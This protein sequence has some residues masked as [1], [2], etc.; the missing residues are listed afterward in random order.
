MKK[1]RLIVDAKCN[2]RCA[3]CC[4][5]QFDITKLPVCTDYTP[6]DEIILTG[7]EPMLFPDRIVEIVLAIDAQ[8][9][10]HGRTPIYMN[11]AK[12]DNVDDMNNVLPWLDGV[13]LTLHNQKDVVTFCKI[14]SSDFRSVGIKS[15]HSLRVNHRAGLNLKAIPALLRRRWTFKEI[16]AVFTDDCPLPKDEVLMRYSPLTDLR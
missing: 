9:R 11:T 12:L 13:T 7:G 15:T 5:N 14:F 4:N 1:L 2:R 6:Y 3:G 16:P 8:K 10:N